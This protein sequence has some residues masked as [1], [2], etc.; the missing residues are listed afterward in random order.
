MWNEFIGN[1]GVVEQLRT[2]AA[3]GRENRLQRTLV[4][5][6]PEG[7]GKATLAVMLGMALNCLHPPAPGDICGQC[8]LCRQTSRLDTLPEQIEAALAH[9]AAEVKTNPRAAAPLQLALHPAIRLYPADG[10]FLSLPQARA[11]IHQTQLLPDAGRTWTLIIPDLDQA[12]WTTQAALL[13]TLEE[14]PPGVVLVALAGNPGALL[15]TVRSRA[16]ELRLA[17]LGV[18]ELTRALRQRRPAETGD[19]ELAARLAHG[20]PGR[21]LHFDVAA[22][23]DARREVLQF[24][25]AGVAGEPLTSVFRLSES[26]RA[27]KEKFVSLLEIL[28]SVLQDIL[29][30][31]SDFSAGI[32]NV[33]CVA[34]MN[35]LAQRIA[36][37]GVS[38]AIA[39]LDRIQAAARRNAFRPLAL[40]SWA[41]SLSAGR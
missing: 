31:Q 20:C 33:D 12:R 9:R 38:D 26:T 35:E 30:L 11:I 25:Q 41:L 15:P 27:G 17:P 1:H 6:G 19:A 18:E 28:Y 3:A 37:A 39:G 24:L 36:P 13:K 14:P 10:D 2:L 22:Y 23:R 32:G 16:L 4:L 34:D 29:Y 8:A 7:I 21:A 5:T 40:A